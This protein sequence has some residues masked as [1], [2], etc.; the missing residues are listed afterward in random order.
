MLQQSHKVWKQV[1]I[2]TGQARLDPFCSF[3]H[4]S[5]VSWFSRIHSTFPAAV[6]YLPGK[7]VMSGDDKQ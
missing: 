4:G 3:E 1:E 7:M 5:N 2:S 6:G